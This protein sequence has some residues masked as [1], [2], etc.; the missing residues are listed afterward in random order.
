MGFKT[1]TPVETSFVRVVYH[2]RDSQS[3]YSVW[4]RFTPLS[5]KRYYRGDIQ[6]LGYSDPDVYIEEWEVPNYLA[7]TLR[8]ELSTYN[9]SNRNKRMYIRYRTIRIVYHDHDSGNIYQ[10]WDKYRNN[11]FTQGLSRKSIKKLGYLNINVYVEDWSVP[12]PIV[13]KIMEEVK[14]YDQSTRMLATHLD[15]YNHHKGRVIC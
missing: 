5:T 1:I 13:N 14:P 11:I 6:T 10:I 4:H 2:N 8:A 7:D 15:H 3:I 12:W 9:L